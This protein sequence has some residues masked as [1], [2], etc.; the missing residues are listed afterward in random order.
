MHQTLHQSKLHSLQIS[1]LVTE[2][3]QIHDV[4]YGCYKVST[5]KKKGQIN[6][7]WISHG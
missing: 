6:V 3:G 1:E 5:K 2:L 7:H 4:K